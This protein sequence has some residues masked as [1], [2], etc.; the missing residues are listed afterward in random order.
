[1]FSRVALFALVGS[2]AVACSTA[3]TAPD[4]EPTPTPVQTP[5]PLPSPTP[6]PVPDPIAQYRVTFSSTWSEQS[7]P[8]DWPDN[9]HYSGLI[10]G[11]HNNRVVFWQDGQ[12]A[13]EGIRAMAERGRKSPLDLEVM[14]AITAG[15]AQHVLSGPDLDTSPASVA[16]EFEIS[17]GFPLVTLVTM[18]APSPDWFVGVSALPLLVN[19]QWVEEQV[20][21]LYPWDAGTDSGVTYEA[22][23]FRTLPAE[24]IR[25]LLGFPVATNGAVAPF[26]TMT[27]RRVK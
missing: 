3:P 6:A 4:P 20:V 7:H 26:G 14:S 19:N 13:S 9:A 8:V 22:D 25:R 15:N 18:V 12:L 17:L 11:T 27:F 21:V 16:M 5:A 24:P 1:M 10:G 23:D 2:M